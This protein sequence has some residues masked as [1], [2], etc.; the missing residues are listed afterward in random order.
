MG[1]LCQGS[2]LHQKEWSLLEAQAILLLPRSDAMAA[3]PA[4][5]YGRYNWKHFSPLLRSIPNRFSLSSGRPVR[6]GHRMHRGITQTGLMAAYSLRKRHL[7]SPSRS[8]YTIRTKVF[9][10]Q[11]LRTDNKIITEPSD[12][13]ESPIL[14]FQFYTYQ[15]QHRHGT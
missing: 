2:I 5:L 9:H 7:D 12:I 14:K 11:K 4:R 15:K 8:H 10:H 6:V 3:Q 13:A 1:T